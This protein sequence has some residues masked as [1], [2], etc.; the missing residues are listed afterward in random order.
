[1][2]AGAIGAGATE[3]QQKDY[4]KNVFIKYLEYLANANEKEAL[5]LE[6]VLFTVLQATDKDVELIEKARMKSQSGFWSYFS[7]SQLGSIVARPLQVKGASG[8]NKSS[9]LKDTSAISSTSSAEDMNGVSSVV[10]DNRKY[11]NI[12]L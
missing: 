6:K 8:L 9:N 10:I 11:F 7:S 4:I 12:N 5:T 3:Q 1:M 2:L